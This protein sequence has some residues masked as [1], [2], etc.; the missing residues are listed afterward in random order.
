MAKYYVVCHDIRTVIS[1]PH[2]E[3]PEEAAIE[4]LLNGAK[5]GARLAPVM[6]VSEKGFDLNSHGE[7]E[8]QIYA[9]DKIMQAAG[10]DF[11]EECG[12]CNGC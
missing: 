4:A 1:G 5:H 2:I 11:G 12:G 3:S 7:N 10:F 6:I 9:T 8:D